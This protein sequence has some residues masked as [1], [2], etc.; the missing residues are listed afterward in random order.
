MSREPCPPAGSAPA[1]GLTACADTSNSAAPAG[2]HG[3]SSR[4]T[5][6]WQRP[7]WRCPGVPTGTHLLERAAQQR[8]L[9]FVGGQHHAVAHLAAEP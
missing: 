9:G 5:H 1:L 8:Q 7:Q 4:C 3:T 6:A 2:P